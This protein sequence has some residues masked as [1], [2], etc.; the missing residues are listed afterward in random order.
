MP[1]CGGQ[2][3]ALMKDSLPVRI[4]AIHRFDADLM[5]VA[6]PGDPSPGLD[7]D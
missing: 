1:I 3:P 5:V 6:Y 4:A 7:L 2:G